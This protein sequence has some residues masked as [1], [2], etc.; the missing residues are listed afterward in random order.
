LRPVRLAWV[1]HGGKAPDQDDAH[2]ALKA[3]NMK[4]EKKTPLWSL[5]C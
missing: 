2:H 5:L 4:E 1:E 3:R